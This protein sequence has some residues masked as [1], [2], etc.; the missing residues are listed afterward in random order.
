V[1]GGGLGQ[2]GGRQGGLGGLLDASKPNAAL[3]S[4]LKANAS[5]YTWVAA[6]NRANSAAG[7]QLAAGEPVMAIGGFN[8]TDPA[9]TLAQFEQYVRAGKIHY[10]ISSDSGLGGG[11]FGAG[12]AGDT[13]GTASAIASW[14]KAN[15]KAT[16][17]GG[18]TVYDLSAATAS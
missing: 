9:P 4:A 1:P 5:S 16:T 6:I 11:R 3:V 17:I 15:F 13:G 7:I 12:A 8:G 2:L 10:Y 18:S 14:V